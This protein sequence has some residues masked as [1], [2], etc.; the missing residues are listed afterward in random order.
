MKIKGTHLIISSIISLFLLVVSYWGNNIRR[1]LLENYDLIRLIEL[2]TDGSLNKH[3]KV[4]PSNYLLINTAF[5]KS[6]IDK[7]EN[8]E[9]GGRIIGKQFITDRRKLIDFLELAK[10][11]DYR[12]LI[13]DW[14][15]QKN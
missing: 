15:F 14:I 2:I 13:I 5:D 7:H 8:D 6:S 9:P 4:E 1:P 11:S 3:N 12:Y 10:Q